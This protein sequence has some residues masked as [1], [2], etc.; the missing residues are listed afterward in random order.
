MVSGCTIPDT[1]TPLPD[2][3]TPLPPGLGLPYPPGVEKT[4]CLGLHGVP[5]PSPINTSPSFNQLDITVERGEGERDGWRESETER[6]EG[7]R[8]LK[9]TCVGNSN[10]FPMMEPPS[11]LSVGEPTVCLPLG[12]G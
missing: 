8:I 10:M 11:W 5:L 4:L 1:P 7:S 3:P 12:Q 9:K 2:T 6:E